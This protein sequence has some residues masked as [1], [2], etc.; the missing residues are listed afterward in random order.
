MQAKSSVSN[1]P[2][3]HPIGAKHLTLKEGSS[4]VKIYGTWSHS[5]ITDPSTGEKITN[6]IP[7]YSV[8]YY[9]AG[10]K[11]QKRFTDLNKAKNEARSVL[12]K[13]TNNES[14]ALKLTGLDH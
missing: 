4:R 5:K 6:F 1:K 10:K 7:E 2:E 11:H 12:T 8:R 9:I 14:E 13:I 3:A